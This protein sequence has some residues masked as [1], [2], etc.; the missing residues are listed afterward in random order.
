MRIVMLETHLKLLVRGKSL[1]LCRGAISSGFAIACSVTH[2]AIGVTGLRE[3][4]LFIAKDA[5]Y[6]TT[7]AVLAPG[8]DVI[9][10][11]RRL[12]MMILCFSAAA[13]WARSK[14]RN[15]QPRV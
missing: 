14:R 7:R 4:F 11:S 2:A 5:H 10:S 3:V 6:P 12:E 13:V 8:M 1:S 9:T 15:L